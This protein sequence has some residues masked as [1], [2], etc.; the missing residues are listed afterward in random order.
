MSPMNAIDNLGRRIGK[1]SPAAIVAVLAPFLVIGLSI[2]SLV[3]LVMIADKWERR[4]WDKAVVLK[5]CP[6]GVPVVR[7][8]NGEVWVRLRWALRYPVED[9]RKVCP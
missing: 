2:G 9:E 4:G 1:L 8:P 3:A 6:G 5:I 7:L